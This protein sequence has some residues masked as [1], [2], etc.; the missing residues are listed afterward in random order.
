MVLYNL[1]CSGSVLWQLG[2]FGENVEHGFEHH[3]REG[4]L[5]YYYFATHFL[6]KFMVRVGGYIM[7]VFVGR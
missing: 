5:I 4:M 6:C 7:Y 2:C 3:I 1:G